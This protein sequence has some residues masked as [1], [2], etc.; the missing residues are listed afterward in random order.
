MYFLFPYDLFPAN[1]NSGFIGILDNFGFLHHLNTIFSKCAYM[2]SCQALDEII[3]LMSVMWCWQGYVHYFLFGGTDFLKLQLIAWQPYSDGKTSQKIVWHIN[4]H[5]TIWGLCKLN[6]KNP[7]CL[8]ASFRV[9]GRWSLLSLD[10]ARL[11][12]SPCSRS[13]CWLCA[14][15]C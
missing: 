7:M 13:L 2:L 1:E 8:L 10:R 12:D 6:K 9:A 5:K 15:L 11:A 3:T 14:K 4:P